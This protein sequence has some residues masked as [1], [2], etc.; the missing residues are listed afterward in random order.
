M[1]RAV[2]TPHSDKSRPAYPPPLLCFC[3]RVLPRVIPNNVCFLYICFFVVD[4]RSFFRY[5][6]FFL[7]L[8]FFQ[9]FLLYP[10]TTDP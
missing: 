6:T 5:G 1:K 9:D 2:V 10:V 3:Y 4:I 8:V 7:F